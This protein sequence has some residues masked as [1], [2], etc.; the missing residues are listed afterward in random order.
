LAEGEASV[1]DFAKPDRERELTTAERFVW[2]EC[3]ICKAADGEHCRADVGIQLGVKVD[4]SRM[5]DGEGA[6]LAR[7]QRAPFKVREIPI[8]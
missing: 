7:L 6:H 1:T 4:G 5:R 8:S 2:G 3:P